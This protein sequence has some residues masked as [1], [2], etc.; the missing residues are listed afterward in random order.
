MNS[1]S[2]IKAIVTHFSALQ[3][4]NNQ[5]EGWK[6]YLNYPVSTDSA[7]FEEAVIYAL[8]ALG[9][10]L[11][12]IEIKAKNAGVPD[13]CYKHILL[14]I[15]KSLSTKY[16]HQPWRNSH[17]GVSPPEVR[18]CLSWLSWAL[19]QHSE[20]E[21]GQEDMD[22]LL[23]AI[24]EQENLLTITQMPSGLR[25][26][27]EGQLVELKIALAMYQINGSKPIVDAVNKQCGEMRNA[28]P[29]L[30]EE[31]SNS[32]EEVKSALAKG[33]ELISK[34]AKAAENGSK[35]FK[36]GQ[37]V[38]QLGSAGW[39]NFGQGLLTSGG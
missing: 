11:R 24:L 3:H 16:L 14:G 22:G 6:T 27:L 9:V 18:M 10:E 30:V 39:Q 5:I 13:E 8:R 21:I 15:S 38:Y 12:S 32:S 19:S 36:F 20:I 31:V 26:L 23:A 1:A 29:D 35:I 28:A 37:E 4:E 17:G 33:M 2:R 25:E 7:Q 34:A